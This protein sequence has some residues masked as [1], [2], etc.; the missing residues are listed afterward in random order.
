MHYYYRPNL[1]KQLHIFLEK[2]EETFFDFNVRTKFV[3]AL[4]L[5]IKLKPSVLFQI[6]DGHKFWNW[7]QNNLVNLIS[8]TENYNGQN[9]KQW[10]K[11]YLSDGVNVRV[12]TLRLRQVRVEPGISFF[13]NG[14][15]V[16]LKYMLNRR[17]E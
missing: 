12:G 4:I 13:S 9:T 5:C 17:S 14:I 16:P 3:L 2:M 11:R 1:T 10:E 15:Y 7:A 6:T 8:Y